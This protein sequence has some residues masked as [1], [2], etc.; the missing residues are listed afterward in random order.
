[1]RPINTHHETNEEVESA[2]LPPGH[3]DSSIPEN[4]C[5]DKEN[6]RLREREQCTAPDSSPVRPSERFLQ[7]LAV[8]SKTVIFPRKRSDGT[9]RSSSFTGQVGG[10]F[11]GLFVG[12]ILE[13]DNSLHELVS[14]LHARDIKQL[15]RRT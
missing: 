4:E 12:L 10:V 13:H 1:M 6:E 5:N 15:T 3:K 14:S 7:T 9:N 11:M 8:Q 2:S